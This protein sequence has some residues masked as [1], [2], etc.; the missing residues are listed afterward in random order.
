MPLLSSLLSPVVVSLG[1]HGSTLVCR[2][3]LI[4]DYSRQP[5]LL[6][7]YYRYRYSL[8][9]VLSLSRLS[10]SVHC[11]LFP[12]SLT[13]Y[14]LRFYVVTIEYPL[15]LPIGLSASRLCPSY[16]LTLLR[17]LSARILARPMLPSIIPPVYTSGV[18]SFGL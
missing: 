17:V 10:L 16:R 7:C 4:S 13:P 2:S 1:A 11:L 5:A 3:Y 9:L 6:Y 12:E 8:P 18:S 15:C 14:V